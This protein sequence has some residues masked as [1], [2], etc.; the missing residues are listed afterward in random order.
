MISELEGIDRKIKAADKELTHRRRRVIIIDRRIVALSCPDGKE[1]TSP[2]PCQGH[3]LHTH[4]RRPGLSPLG[5]D[6]V[7]TQREGTPA[8]ECDGRLGLGSGCGLL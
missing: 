8:Q 4:R 3:G 1:I 2:P 6:Q 7:L 5:A